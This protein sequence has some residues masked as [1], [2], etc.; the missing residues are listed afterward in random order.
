MRQRLEFYLARVRRTPLNNA[1]DRQ[2]HF[3]VLSQRGVAL[4]CSRSN[5]VN[6]L[7]GAASEPCTSKVGKDG[8]LGPHAAGRLRLWDTMNKR[9]LLTV[10]PVKMSSDQYSDRGSFLETQINSRNVVND[11]RSRLQLTLKRSPNL[12]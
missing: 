3:S 1:C 7:R 9:P 8:G 11:C 12:R 2:L 10:N 4:L 6:F 5:G